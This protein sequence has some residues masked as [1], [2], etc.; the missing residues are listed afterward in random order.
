MAKSLRTLCQDALKEI[1][2]VNVPSSFVG[3][4]NPTAVQMVALANRVLKDLQ[5]HKWQVVLSTHTFST[6]A[7]TSAYALPSDFE[8]FANMTQWDRTNYEDVEGPVSPAVWEALRSSNLYAS[9]IKRY[10]R[11]AAGQFEIYP[12]PDAADTIAYQYY[13]NQ[14]ITSKTEFSDDTDVSLI[15]EDAI[16]LG[17]KYYW[18]RAKGLDW[19]ADERDYRR[20]IDIKQANDGGK[21]VLRFG[22]PALSPL[23]GGN[24]PDTGYGS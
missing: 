12:T 13:S 17:L 19:A 3:N 5:D 6:V 10:F 24:I 18:R 16:T 14:P 8:S 21:P 22:G 9:G 20:K 1:G 23:S 11:V 4:T 2:M 15:Y 7:S